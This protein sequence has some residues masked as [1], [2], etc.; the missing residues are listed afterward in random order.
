[1]PPKV[2]QDN[3]D[4][5]NQNPCNWMCPAARPPGPRL[6]EDVEAYVLLPAARDHV[7]QC[8]IIRNKH[9]MDKGFFPSY[10]LYQEAE[11]GVAV[12]SSP[13]AGAFPL[14]DRGGRPAPDSSGMPLPSGQG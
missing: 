12:S 8:R 9:G 10:Y 5:S 1:M 7:V 14:G 11:D 13:G 6:G 4:P 3:K 2:L